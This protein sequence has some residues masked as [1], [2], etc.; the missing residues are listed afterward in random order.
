MECLTEECKDVENIVMLDNT[1]YYV[2]L[3]EI[4]EKITVCI[5]AEEFVKQ[6]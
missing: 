3:A 5:I 4:G 2:T 1:N 6:L